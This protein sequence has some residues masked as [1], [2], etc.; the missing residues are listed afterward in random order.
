MEEG[1]F[2]LSLEG[3]KPDLPL[4]GPFL[5]LNLDLCEKRQGDPRYIVKGET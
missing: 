3:F 5:T 2:I 1:H 4:R